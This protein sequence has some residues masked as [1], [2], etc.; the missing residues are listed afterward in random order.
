MVRAGA[1]KRIWDYALYFEA[2]VRSHTA[3]YVSILQREVPETV[4]T[5]VTSY[6]GQFYDH[7]L[8]DWVIFRDEP[9][10]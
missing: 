3:L 5:S 1:P 2:C 6:I 4:M 9:T 8:Y 10:Q 7:G